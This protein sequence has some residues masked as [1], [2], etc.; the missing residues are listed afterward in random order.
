MA[1]RRRPRRLLWP[2]P[3]RIARSPARTTAASGDPAVRRLLYI[4]V[5]GATPLR[6]SAR[7]TRAQLS[8]CLT[9]LGPDGGGV[10]SKRLALEAPRCQPRRKSAGTSCRK[11]KRAAPFSPQAMSKH[12]A[13]EGTRARMTGSVSICVHPRGPVSSVM[14]QLRESMRKRLLKKQVKNSEPWLASR[15]M[16]RH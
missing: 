14:H 1:L 9:E 11:G 15:T 5:C 7:I 2:P 16:R 6:E 4:V 10:G 13:V 12:S 3:A 8:S